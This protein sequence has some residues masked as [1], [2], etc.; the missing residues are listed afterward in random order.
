[1][2]MGIWELS[3]GAINLILGVFFL[4]SASFDWE[5][6]VEPPFDASSNGCNHRL[7]RGFNRVAAF[8]K[9]R[10]TYPRTGYVA[11]RRLPPARAQGAS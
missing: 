2:K 11:Y 5:R 1:M 6:P 8:L 7:F 10:I 3:F 9:E 4:V